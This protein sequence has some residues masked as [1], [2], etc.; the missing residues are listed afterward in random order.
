MY[1]RMDERRFINSEE[2]KKRAVAAGLVSDVVVGED[3]AR[4][5]ARERQKWG[6]VIRR[7][8]IRIE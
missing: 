7:N 6:E 4:L 8:N 2:F 3:F 1:E 5:I